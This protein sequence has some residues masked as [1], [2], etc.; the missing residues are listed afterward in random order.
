MTDERSI[1]PPDA[2]GPGLEELPDDVREE[3]V[4]DDPRVADEPVEED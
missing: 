2:D 4:E 3:P 1:D